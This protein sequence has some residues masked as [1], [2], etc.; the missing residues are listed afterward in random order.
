M[1]G[2]QSTTKPSR[3]NRKLKRR[4]KPVKIADLV[5]AS[6]TNS[7][8]AATIAPLSQK[9]KVWSRNQRNGHNR[10]LNT[11]VFLYP[12]KSNAAL[13]RL[14]SIRAGLFGQRSAL[15]GSV[16]SFRPHLSPPPNTVESI[17]GGYSPNNGV[18]A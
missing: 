2:H 1:I 10:P 6:L 16:T 11:V 15:A 13:I 12:P 8:M 9:T 5:N 4:W 14:F 18:T 7:T 3:M 17:N